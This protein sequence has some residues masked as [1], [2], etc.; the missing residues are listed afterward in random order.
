MPSSLATL[1]ALPSAVDFYAQYWNN[2][3]FLVRGAID[4]A[5]MD[6]LIA[7]DE[8]AGLSMED[9]VRARLVSRTDWACKFGPFAEEDFNTADDPPWSLLVQNVEQ[10]HPATAALLRAFG[11]AP[12]WLM[13]DIMASFS[14]AGGTIGGHVDSYHVF[15]VQGQGTRRWTIG[16]EPVVD[17][18][19]I[20]GLDLKILHDPIDG[21]TVDVTSGDV[22]YVPPHFAHEGTTLDDALTFSV[23]FLGPKLSELYDAYAQHLAQ[24]DAIDRRYE[25]QG[26]NAD[27]AGFAL[28]ADAVET[29]RAH[30]GDALNTPA[31]AGW[32][33]TFFT[34]STS[35]DEAHHS[36]RDAPLT[37][38]AFAAAL[39]AGAGLVKPAYAKFALVPTSGS[40]YRLGFNR[41]TFDI[42]PDA[43]DL[44]LS[45]MKEEP[46]TATDTPALR[47]HFD[48]LCRLY[49]DQALDLI[50]PVQ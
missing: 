32:L 8:L 20:D 37:L 30:L 17:P 46:I 16:D 48:L 40:A 24:D 44:I 23:G 9:T 34:G 42:A 15:L 43:L 33:A 21:N 22:L 49:N 45:L 41:E 3:P 19:F 47:D 38:A 11:F 10:F 14:T 36:P 1:D 5:I 7:P 39:E 31:F 12:R 26:L 35:E 28:S 25:G 18:R 2:R 27:S 13:D 29:L 4:P 6:G 50:D